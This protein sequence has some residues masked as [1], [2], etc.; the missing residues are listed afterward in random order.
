MGP[1]AAPT[2]VTAQPAPVAHA[3]IRDDA[4]IVGF[5]QGR[6]GAQRAL[7]KSLDEQVNPENLRAWMEAMTERP[8]HAG[9][10]QD[11][12]NVE[13]MAELFRSWGYEAEIVEYQVLFP[14]PKVRKLELVAPRKFKAKL[15]E[16]VLK[17]DAV[18]KFDKDR[19]PPFNAFAADGDVTADLV[20]VNYGV[21]EDYDV[22]ER[23]GVDVKGKIVIARYGRA[24][25]GIK[26]KLAAEKG[27]IG[28][29]IYSDPAD[30]GYG[31]GDSYP[32]GAYRHPESVQRGSVYDLPQR[33]GDPL[34]PFV[35]ATKDAKRLPRE[36]AETLVKIPVLPISYADAQPLL[37]ALG[38]EVVPSAWRGALPI[39]YHAGPGPARVHLQLESS[40]DLAPAYNVVAKLRG[41]E[42]PDEWIIRG[43]HHDAWV[44][45][46]SDPVSGMVAVMEEARVVAALAKAGRPP[47]RTVVY[48]GWGAEE[49]GIIGSTEWV[50]ANAELLSAK[51]AVYVNSDSN[52]RGFL[53]MGGSH[54]LTRLV[55]GAAR[56]VID[57]QVGIPVSERARARTLVRGSAAARGAVEG[58][59]DLPIS[60]LGSG[61]D[62]TPFIQ[63]L[64][65]SSLN[66]GFGG[67]NGGGSYHSTYDSFDH[68]TRF[69]DPG[70]AYGGAL[71]KVAGRVT[72]RLANADVLPFQ[73][74]TL[75]S[76]ISGYAGE[77]ETMVETR[78]K[79]V[80]RNNAWI[81][82]GTYVAA[83][84]PTRPYVAPKPQPPV[85]HVNFAPLRNAV[86][87]VQ[88]AA[89]A[90]DQALQTALA[91][92][93]ID[94]GLAS[95]IDALIMQTE[96]SL[97]PADGLPGRPW[98]RHLVYAPGLLT[99]YGVK[100]L[101]GVREAIE[102]NRWAEAEDEITQVSAAL[103]AL[104]ET[105]EK[106]AD[107]L[108]PAGG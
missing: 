81:E 32:Q 24:W 39:T 3:P 64:G 21:Q 35:G 97:A 78:R 56:E 6:A 7:E 59:G 29:I 102:A 44:A 19:L 22:L 8:H 33:V 17:Q 23:M 91:R 68:Y 30:D 101:P 14:T 88:A 51:A 86:A 82:N 71:V 99:G 63:H 49:P 65:V 87:R 37:E 20:Y 48:A 40:W 98:Y 53:R 69:G 77:L 26:P 70:F 100:T 1:T 5:T 52:G 58:G 57:P 83:A 79:E 16:P 46:A 93:E 12:K 18:S 95:E 50:E 60:A 43:N 84:D 89:T 72:L 103:I 54:A 25:R 61:S 38:G 47:R 96:R 36:Q 85:P 106:A 13:M 4:S 41:A 107:K 108:S 75:A 27:A 104:A 10:P 90:F 94:R 92:A 34:T 55:N 45:G 80:A 105:L 9:S 74:G 62:Y 28:C 42:L 15:R 67:E 2:V 76:T 73:F 11:R 31:R 66:L